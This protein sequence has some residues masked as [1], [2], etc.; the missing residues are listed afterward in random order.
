MPATTVE[1]WQPKKNYW[2]TLHRTRDGFWTFP[3]HPAVDKPIARPFKLRLTAPNG[4]SVIDH[5]NPP[6]MGKSRYLSLIYNHLISLVISLIL[7]VIM[8]L[9]MTSCSTIGRLQLSMTNCYTIVR[10]TSLGTIA[11][12]RDILKCFR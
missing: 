8:Q 12:L 2:V 6:S 3:S 9:S 7:C 4:Q 11:I 1:M 10:L 5:V